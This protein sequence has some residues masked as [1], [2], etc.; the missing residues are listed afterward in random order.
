VAPGRYAVRAAVRHG[1]AGIAG[2][3]HGYVDVPD[4]GK[5]RLSLSGIVLHDPQAR[6]VT[7]PEALGGVIAEAPTV[8]R[9]FRSGDLITALGRVYQAAGPPGAV[10]VD[11]RVLDRDERQLHGR[12]IALE[13]GD[14]TNGAADVRFELPLGELPPG[15][16]ALVVEAA[17]G[18]ATARRDVLFT[19][20]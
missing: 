3:V 18:G 7:P 9:R 2:S 15:A 8:R 13:A 5:E 20:R 11:F 19:M 12:R 17:K 1:R 16:Y 4:F 6:T 14:F 10:S